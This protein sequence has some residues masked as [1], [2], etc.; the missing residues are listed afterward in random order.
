MVK[1]EIN[2]TEIENIQNPEKIQ[3]PEKKPEKLP[4]SGIFLA[5]PE[6]LATLITV[7]MNLAKTS[8]LNCEK[9]TWT[10][11]SDLNDQSEVFVRLH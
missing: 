3:K 6:D 1:N 10:R 7:H 11:L 2:I 8:S 5:N 4:K 9:Q